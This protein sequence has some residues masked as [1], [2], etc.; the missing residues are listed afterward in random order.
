MPGITE[1]FTL[2]GVLK[3]TKEHNVYE[4][5]SVSVLR[6]G[7]G[8]QLLCWFRY[9]ELTSINLCE[10]HATNNILCEQT[11]QFL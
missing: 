8:G 1:F 10:L 6:W 2:S 5:I 3:N 4:I 7:G 9:R 11:P